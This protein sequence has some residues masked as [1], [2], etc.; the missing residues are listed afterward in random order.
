M[1]RAIPDGF[2][3][4]GETVNETKE[5]LTKLP[6]VLYNDSDNPQP[7]LHPFDPNERARRRAKNK[8]AKKARKKN[9]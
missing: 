9:R 3:K 6:D 4:V 5:F 2:T 1:E 8:A 7:L